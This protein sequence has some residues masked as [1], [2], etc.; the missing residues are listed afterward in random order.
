L[1]GLLAPILATVSDAWL[2]GFGI[3]QVLFAAAV[4]VVLFAQ[5][6]VMRRVDTTDE[7]LHELTSK[8]VDER[9][10]AMTHEINGSVGGFKL[11]LEELKMRL[12]EGEETFDAIIRAGHTQELKG[13]ER[14]EQ[15]KDYIRDQ[16]ASR[17]DLREHQNKADLKFDQIMRQLAEMQASLAVANERAQ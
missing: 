14:L 4:S 7:R 2:I 6:R 3:F 16:T 17:A 13:L 11:T 1:K 9:F 8:L 5:G 10:R 15:V 12:K